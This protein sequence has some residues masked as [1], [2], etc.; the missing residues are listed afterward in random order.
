MTLVFPDGY[1][2]WSIRRMIVFKELWHTF[3]SFHR[4]SRPTPDTFTTLKRTPGISPL[5]LPRRPKPEMRTSSFSS[6]KFRQPSFYTGRQ[7]IVHKQQAKHDAQVRKPWPSF[8]SWWAVHGHISELQSWV[9]LPRRRL[10]RAQFPLHEMNLRW[11]R[12]CRCYRGHV[13]CRLC[14]PTIMIKVRLAKNYWRGAYPAVFTAIGAELT[15]G[16]ESARFVC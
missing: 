4:A 6:T 1:D 8:R 13:S 9:V 12:F 14:P 16:L 2:F 11:V 5:A 3:F 7:L 15:S 10:S